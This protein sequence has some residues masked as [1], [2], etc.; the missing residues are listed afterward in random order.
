MEV[1]KNK[2]DNVRDTRGGRVRSIIVSM[3][4]VKQRFLRSVVNKE[5]WYTQ[6]NQ[7]ERLTAIAN[8]PSGQIERF[9]A[10]YEDD[11]TGKKTSATGDQAVEWTRN[12]YHS[13]LFRNIADRIPVGVQHRPAWNEEDGDIEIS[14]LYG[15][16]DDFYLGINERISKPG[17]RIQFG[18]SF[19]CGVSNKVI[20][21]YGAWIFGLIA[22]MESQGFDMT[23][24]AAMSVTELFQ[25]ERNV[26]SHVLLRVKKAGE[27]SNPAD[28][29]VLFSPVGFR[30]IGFTAFHVAGD[31]IGKV[32]RGNLGYPATGNRW[33]L[34]YD[35]DTSTVT[36]FCNSSAYSRDVFPADVLTA[37]AVEAGLLPSPE[38]QEI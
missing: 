30:V 11:A 32:C 10:E 3:D 38:Q 28:W 27:I 33:D 16:Y 9:Y 7:Q 21:Q 4:S 2:F 20:A 6:R 23:I 34:Q 15:G 13:R 18:L 22:G 5:A 29:S 24:D 37:K 17:I 35:K 14:R 36:I 25:G 31:K 26:K 19:S 12:G 1:T 8:N